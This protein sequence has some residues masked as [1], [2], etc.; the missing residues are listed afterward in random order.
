VDIVELCGS[1]EEVMMRHFSGFLGSALA[2]AGDSDAFSLIV[3]VSGATLLGPEHPAKAL[4]EKNTRTIAAAL[5]KLR[6][7]VGGFAALR[8]IAG[9]G[10]AR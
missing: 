10:W 4:R 8:V 2:A 5:R 7:R 1:I 9:L 3:A 6:D